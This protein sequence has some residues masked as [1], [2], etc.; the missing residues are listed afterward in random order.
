MDTDKQKIS[1]DFIC[2]KCFK[3]IEN[4]KGIRPLAKA[5][6]YCPV[7]KEWTSKFLWLK[8]WQKGKKNGQEDQD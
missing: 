6:I 7:C 8:Y 1:K 5:E 3:Q 2:L 4:E